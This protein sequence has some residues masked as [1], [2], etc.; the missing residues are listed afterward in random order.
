MHFIRLVKNENART[1]CRKLKK[2]SYRRSQIVQ[3]NSLVTLFYVKY[4]ILLNFINIQKYSITL[5]LFSQLLLE[6][7]GTTILIHYWLKLYYS[8][9]Y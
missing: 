5:N 3:L 8:K 4:G 7:L 6:E 9:F 1:H 2:R